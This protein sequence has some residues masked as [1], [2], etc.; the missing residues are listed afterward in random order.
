[1]GA[2]R[3]ITAGVAMA[4]GQRASGGR[5]VIPSVPNLRRTELVFL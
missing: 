4:L 5:S 2:H 3:D 1:M